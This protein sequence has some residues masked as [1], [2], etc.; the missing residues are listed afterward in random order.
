MSDKPS[1]EDYYRV[2]KGRA[3]GTIPYNPAG[4]IVMRESR[5]DK[6]KQE[7]KVCL[8]QVT[9]VAGAVERAKSELKA[10]K[11]SAATP[12]RSTKKRSVTK[13]KKESFPAIKQWQEYSRKH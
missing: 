9:P 13:P 6:D 10:I 3:E 2:L 5:K 7:P 1:W 11:E 8:K 12:K 4:Y